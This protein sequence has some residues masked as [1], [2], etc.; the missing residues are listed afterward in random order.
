M[1]LVGASSLNS[2][3]ITGNM[4]QTPYTLAAVAAEK[5]ELDYVKP[6]FVKTKEFGY[7]YNGK[8]VSTLHTI[9]SDYLKYVITYYGVYNLRQ[10]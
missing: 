7:R 2:Y 4:V 5:A 9:N 1:D 6:E 3:N 8:K 10:Q